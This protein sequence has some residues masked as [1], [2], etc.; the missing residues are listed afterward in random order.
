[1]TTMTA[2]LNAKANIDWQKYAGAMTGTKSKSAVAKSA[3]ESF[4]NWVERA[5]NTFD[6]NGEPNYLDDQGELIE[7]IYLNMPNDL[8]HSLP[9]LSSSGLKK[10]KESPPHYY[11]QYLSNITTKRTVQQKR[12]FDAGTYGHELVLEP[13][14]YFDRY[15]RMPLPIDFPHALRTEAEIK[16]ALLERQLKTSGS[17]AEK[18]ARL[19]EADPTVPVLDN[20][21]EIACLKHGQPGTK[22]VEGNEVQTYGGKVGIDGQVWDA[23]LRV[24]QSVKREVLADA[25]IRNGLPEVA[26]ISRCPITGMM[27]KVKF[28]WLRFDDQAGDVKTTLSAMPDDFSRQMKKLSYDL[29]Q[30]FYCYVAELAG[31]FVRRFVF[32]AVEYQNADYCQLY[33]LSPKR[34][35]K[36]QKARD[37]LLQEF[38]ECKRLNTWNSRYSGAMIE[39]D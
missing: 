39:L 24:Q 25:F 21:M 9:A 3:E 36:A 15:F 19:L 20:L 32:I 38:A 7:G 30:A 13:Q 33:S 26:I 1:M 8:Y 28:D 14:G 37:E 12:T 6:E 35:A 29:Q 16:E 18:I 4:S 2:T 10:F 5:I 11:R 34:R 27:L 23:A 17:K 22:I 31:I